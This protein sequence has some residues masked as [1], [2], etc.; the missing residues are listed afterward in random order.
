MKFEKKYAKLLE[1]QKARSEIDR[2]KK[3]INALL[4]NGEDYRIIKDKKDFLNQLILSYRKKY[5]K[6]SVK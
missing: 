1:E 3:Y 2:Y 6:V 4:E 5:I